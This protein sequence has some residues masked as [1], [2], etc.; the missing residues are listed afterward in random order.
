LILAESLP[1]HQWEQKP[2]GWYVTSAGRTAE[3]PTTI[4]SLEPTAN[5]LLSALYQQMVLFWLKEAP[6]TADKRE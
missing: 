6:I 4:K 5:R 1:F 3:Q 2:T